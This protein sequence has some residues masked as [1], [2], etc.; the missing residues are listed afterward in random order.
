VSFGFT[1]APARSRHALLWP[2]RICDA[3]NGAVLTFDGS[4]I[5]IGAVWGYRPGDFDPI[6]HVFPI[7]PGPGSAS[8]QNPA[9]KAD[10]VTPWFADRYW[11]RLGSETD[12][13]TVWRPIEVAIVPGGN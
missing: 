12:R 8:R 7:P 10:T 3:A 13:R 2:T 11:R 1:R 5:D 6:R 9:I 4:L